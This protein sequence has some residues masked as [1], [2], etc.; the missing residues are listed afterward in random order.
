MVGSVGF[1]ISFTS[2]EI[3]RNDGLKYY[4]T[5]CVRVL[6]LVD[7]AIREH[8]PIHA[9]ISTDGDSDR[10]L[11]LGIDPDNKVRFFESFEK[12]V[13]LQIL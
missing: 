5:A 4:D 13:R 2:G 1:R 8:G 6:P 9:V 7:D 3:V 11:I 12:P 10:P